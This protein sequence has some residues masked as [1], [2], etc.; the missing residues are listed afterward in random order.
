MAVRL[1][2][3]SACPSVPTPTQASLA[4]SVGIISDSANAYIS[5]SNITGSGA[6]SGRT[7][8][9]DAYQ[10]T[11][12]GIGGGTLYF[13][14]G[15]GGLGVSLTYVS[16]HDPSGRN[17]VDAHVYNTGVSAFDT[18]TV[19]AN[20][21][22]R[23]SAGA[24]AG[25][26]SANVGFAGAVVVNEISP[27]ITAYIGGPVTNNPKTI[28]LTG[29]ASVLVDSNTIAAYNDALASV[30][31]AANEGTAPTDN[32]GIDFS[33][34]ALNGGTAITG[35][36]AMFSVAGILQGGSS[37]VGLS[38][39][40]SIIATTHS[41]F[42][43]NVILNV[44]NLQVTSNDSSTIFGLTIG[45]SFGTGQFSG[46]AGTTLSSIRNTVTAQIGDSTVNAITRIAA[47]GDISVLAI[48]TSKITGVASVA[49]FSLGSAAA[50]LSVVQ[51]TIANSIAATVNNAVMTAGH[52]VTV[53]AE[54]TANISTTAVG[55]AASRSVGLAGSIALN[56]VS[57][58]VVA[59][60]VAADVIAQNNVGV[61]ANNSDNIAVVAGA[62]GVT[63][64]SPSIAGGVSV[65]TNTIGG[66]TEALIN[67]NS[68][69]DALGLGTSVLTVSTGDLVTPFDPSTPNGMTTST[70][71]LAET[72]R[73]VHGLAVVATSHQA[74][75]ANA[76]T[77]GLSI[78]PLSGAFAVVSIQN[79]MGG[80]TKASID[81]SLI[82]TRLTG[83]AT[84]L[85]D[86][87]AS[88]HSYSA[89][90]IIALSL[91]GAS[92]AA[93]NASN[94]LK[95]QTIANL[96]NSTA[97]TTNPSYTGT[98]IDSVDINAKAS[99]AAADV[100]IGTAAGIGSGASSGVL[101]N[102]NADTEAYADRG[103]L[104]ARQLIVNAKSTN[105]FFAEAGTGAGGAIGLASSYVVA[106]TSNKTLAYIG[107]PDGL[108][109]LN[110]NGKLAVTA[111][112]ENEFDSL[113][114]G[115][116]LGGGAGL[117]GMANVVT[118]SNTTRAGLYNV[119]STQASGALDGTNAAGVTVTAVENITIKPTTGAGVASAGLGLGSAT[120]VAVLG[121]SLTAEIVNT[122]NTSNPN[123][124]PGINSP[125]TVSVT[126]T[127]TKTIN[128]Q[129]VTVGIG[130]S[131]GVG[132]SV[133]V[134]LLGTTASDDANSL[135]NSGGSGTLAAVDA[136]NSVG[137][138]LTL[139]SAGIAAYRTALGTSGTTM[140]DAQIQ[141]AAQAEYS[142]LLQ[143]GTGGS[144]NFALSSS[145]LTLYAP[146]AL[147]MADATKFTTLTTNG[148]IT[149]GVLTLSTAGLA[150]YRPTAVLALGGTP[151]DTQVQAYANS[152]YRSLVS[153]INGYAFTRYQTLKSDA[154]SFVLSEAG[155]TGYRS[156]AV[157][158]LALTC[159]AGTQCGTNAEVISY[160]NDQFQKLTL[161]A[162]GAV[163]G[164][165]VTLNTTGLDAFRVAAQA[166]ADAKAM[167]IATSI[168]VA[169]PNPPVTVTDAQ[170]QAYANAQYRYLIGHQDTSN[171]P[172]AFSVSAALS[173]VNDGVFASIAG[174]APVTAANVNVNATANISTTND[175]TGIGAAGTGAGV[176]A[177]VAYT[178]INDAV[179]ASVTQASVNT[180]TLTIAARVNDGSS[181]P[182]AKVEARA[183]AG[184]G[185][186]A[187]GAA[188]GEA[189]INNSVTAGLGGTVTLTG[190]ANVSADDTSN[191]RANAFGATAGGGLALGVSK[192]VA[193]RTS[194]VSASLLDTSRV[195]AT[196][197]TISASS[198]G[199]SYAAAV[200][201]AGGLFFAG[202][203]VQSIAN[204]NSIIAAHLGKGAT[205]NVGSG[206]VKL[207]AADTPD[208]KAASLGVTV[209]G[210]VAVGTSLAT[211]TASPNVL[212][213]LDGSTSATD[214]ITAGRLT[215]SA[216]SIVGGVP[217]GE[218]QDSS[219]QSTNDF[220]PGGT[221]AA[222]WA[223]AGAGSVYYSGSGTN[224]TANNNSVVAAK[225]G[226]YV[227]LP[228]A[229]VVIK[230]DNT[231]RQFASSTGITVGGVLAVGVVLTD[232]NANTTTM[233]SLG[234]HVQMLSG[235]TK[236]FSLAA[237]GNDNNKAYS[238][239][240]SGGAIAGSGAEARTSTTST[241]TA[242]TGNADNL[243]VISLLI[244]AA[245]T[246]NYSGSSDTRQGGVIGA[247]GSVAKH[248]GDSAVAVNVGNNN[249]LYVYGTNPGSCDISACDPVVQ[250]LATNIFNNTNTG[251]SANAGAG[252][253]INGV[254]AVSTTTLTGSNTINIGKG[255]QI[256]TG[257]D[258]VNNPGS[259][260]I[261]AMSLISG[262]DQ[263]TLSAGSAIAAGAGVNSSLVVTVDNTI[264]VGDAT[265]T[266]AA[267]N[268]TIDSLG[269]ISIGTY[270]ISSASTS[271]YATTFGTILA[272]VDARAT[273]SITTNQNVTIGKALLKGVGDVNV[274]AGQ[275]GS[276][277]FSTSLVDNS[278]AVSYARGLI[279]VPVADA[280]TRLT[281]NTNLNI[282]AGARLQS[283]QNI[284]IGAYKGNLVDTAT[285]SGH[286]YEIFAI[287]V[288]AG[289]THSSS[290]ATSSVAI[291]GMLTAGIYHDLEITISCANA[292]PTCQT[293]TLTQTSGLTASYLYLDSSTFGTGRSYVTDHFHP[294][295]AP[296]LIAGLPAN[297]GSA[298]QL[299][300]LYASGGSV[301][302]SGS[303]LAGS[304][305]ITA[306]GAPI[307]NVQNNTTSSLILAGGAYIPD[308][309]VGQINFIGTA[310]AAQAPSTLGLSRP[311]PA[312]A[313]STI[314]I[315]NSYD[316]GFGGAYGPAL[317]I[318]GDIVNVAGLVNINN[319]SGS[320]GLAANLAAQ[321]VN[322]TIPNGA[323][324]VSANDPSG[325]YLAGGSPF[326]EWANYILYPGG[327][328]RDGVPNGDVAAAYLA[329]TVAG[330]A[331][332]GDSLNR[333]LYGV[334]YAPGN[335]RNSSTIFFGGCIP[336][337][338]GGNGAGCQQY[339]TGYGGFAPGSVDNS[340]T[341]GFAG[342][343]SNT[344]NASFPYIT[345]YSLTKSATSYT[346]AY[347]VGSQ[348]SNQIY[349][350]QVAI[351]ANIIDIN[352]LIT[353]GRNT[354]WSVNLPSSLTDPAIVSRTPVTQ[355]VCTGIFGSSCG[356]QIVDYNTTYSG[357]AISIFKAQYDLAILTNPAANALLTVNVG[358]NG[359][360]AAT[361]NAATNTISLANVNASSGGSN[362]LLDGRIISTNA[363]GHIHV[364]GG[365]GNVQ[366]ANNTG[367]DLIVNGINTGNSAAA[368]ALTS[369]VKIVDRLQATAT[370]TTTYIYSPASNSI[371]KYIT[372]NGANADS[373][374]CMAGN[375][376]TI[377]ASTIDY[378]TKE[379]LRFQWQ[380]YATI[381]RSAGT[382]DAASRTN[383]AL[384]SAHWLFTSGTP[385]NP[386]V[387]LTPGLTVST[388]PQGTLL[389]GQSTTLPIFQERITGS[390]LPSYFG[391]SA[392]QSQPIVYSGCDPG[393]TCNYGFPQNY[394]YN[395]SNN[396]TIYQS[397][398]N[399]DYPIS[400]SLT[401]TQ[402]IK[403]DNQFKVDFGGNP[404]AT[405]NIASNSNVMFANSIINPSGNLTATASGSVEKPGN[406]TQTSA[407]PIL[408][409]SFN[410]TAAGS[411]GTVTKPLNVT[412]TTNGATPGRLAANAGNAGV[413]L[414]L[415]SGATLGRVSSGNTSTGFGD[416]GI[417]A[418]GS[419]L[420]GTDTLVTGRNLTLISTSGSVGTLLAPLNISA[421][422]T[423]LTS[424]GYQ[425]GVVNV[426]AHGDV[427]LIQTA[428][429][430]AYPG[431]LRIGLIASAGGD[432]QINV[433]RGEILDASGQTS[434]QA[435]SP[436]QV[437]AISQA[438][439]LTPLDGSTAASLAV[440]AGFE[441]TVNRDL[442]DYTR[443][444][445]NGAL[446]NGS[447]VLVPAALATYRDLATAAIGHAASDTE[448]QTY[449]NSLYQLY[450]SDFTR[451]FGTTWQT[452]PAII[453]YG[454]YVAL[455][456]AGT[457]IN[458][459]FRLTA[460]DIA[461][462]RA[463]AT[464][465]LGIAGRNATDAETQT[466][467]AGL[468]AT[469][470]GQVTFSA[471]PAVAFSLL[472]ASGSLQNGTFVLTN[473]GILS[474]ASQALTA[475]NY[476]TF[477][478]LLTNGTL[479]SGTFALTSAGIAA[480]A[481]ALL[482]QD[483]QNFQNLN[484]YGSV[485]NGTFTLTAAGV[486]FFRQA[487][488]TAQ[489][490]IPTDAQV[491]AYANTLYQGY[492]QTINTAE[493]SQ[494]QTLVQT[495]KTSAASNYQYYANLVANAYCETSGCSASER[496]TFLTTVPVQSYAYL[497]HPVDRTALTSLLGLGTVTNGVFTLIAGNVG[498]YAQTGLSPSNFA[499]YTGLL[500]AGTVSNNV[501]ALTTAG[502]VQFAQSALTT[503]YQT[504]QSL[505]AS[506]ATQL[507][508][509][510]FSNAGVQQFAQSGI[511][512]AYQ[513]YQALVTN[514][515]ADSNGVFVLSASGLTAYRPLAA[516]ALGIANPTD[517]QVQAYAGQQYQNSIFTGGN[518]TYQQYSQT[519][520]TGAQTQLQTLLQI[521]RV[522][523][524][525]TESNPYCQYNCSAI[526]YSDRT[527]VA[528]Y[529]QD[530]LS[531][532][533]YTA[534]QTLVSNGSFNPTTGAFTLN[535]T[536]AA[537]AALSSVALIGSD[538]LAFQTLLGRGTVTN[539]QFV[540]SSAGAV[541]A[542][543]QL[544]GTGTF[545]TGTFQLTSSGVAA[546]ASSA[547]GYAA[548]QKLL[549][550]G[551][552]NGTTLVLNDPGV[553]YYAPSALSAANYATFSGFIASGNGEVVGGVLTLTANGISAFR[554]AATTSL[555]HAASDAEVQ[556]YARAQYQ[557]FAITVQSYANGQYQSYISTFQNAA[558]SQ[559]QTYA[560]QIRTY[561]NN[562]QNNNGCYFNCTPPTPLA[563]SA[564]AS[565]MQNH[566][567]DLGYTQTDLTA[568]QALVAK[569]A[570]QNGVYSLTSA[571]I[572]LSFADP[573]L[574][575]LK[576]QTFQTVLAGGSVQNGTFVL[577]NNGIIAASRSLA[578][579]ADP[580]T[581][582][583][584]ILNT[585]QRIRI[586]YNSGLIQLDNGLLVSGEQATAY[587]DW[588]QTAAT[589]VYAAG[590][591]Q[592]QGIAVAQYQNYVAPI[593]VYGNGQYQSLL[594]TIQAGAA[595]QY[596]SSTRTIQ[597]YGNSQYQTLTSNG[598]TQ[599]A[600]TTQGVLDLIANN[601]YSDGQIVAA[602]NRSALAPSPT[603]VGNNGNV[604]IVGRNV[605]LTTGAS[606]GSLAPNVVVNL[607]DLR[608]GTVTADQQA[609]I[610]A[611][612]APGSV[613]FDVLV[614]GVLRTGQVLN[615][616][617]TS[618]D[619]NNIVAAQ[620]AQISPVFVNA[621]G[622][623][624]ATASTTVYVQAASALS[625]A[626][627]QL[628]TSANVSTTLPVA[629]LALGQ[630]NAGGD[631]TVQ[632][633]QNITAALNGSGI[634]FYSRQI[635]T[636]GN[637]TIAAGG[638]VGTAANAVTFEIG[639]N[640]VSGSAGADAYLKGLGGDIRVGR[641]SAG[642]TLIGGGTGGTLSLTAQNGN[643]L[644]YLPGVA[645][646]AT[647]IV[648]NASGNVGSSTTP[649]QVQDASGGTLSGAVTGGAWIYGS[650]LSNQ[651]TPVTLYIG[652]FSAAAGVSLLADADIDINGAVVSGN[653]AIIIRTLRP[654]S[655]IVMGSMSSVT[656]GTTI[657]LESADNIVL[658]KLQ[659]TGAGSAG[660]VIALS[661]GGSI[662]GNGDG[663][664]NLLTGAPS[665]SVSLTASSIGT[666]VQRVVISAPS[667]SAT[668]GT[669]DLYLKTLGNTGFASLTTAY[670]SVDVLGTG[671]LVF[672]SVQAGTANGATGN[673][674]A[675][676]SAAAGATIAVGTATT[677]GTQT[678]H[679][680]DDL[681]FTTLTTTGAT[682][683]V[684][685]TSDQGKIAG[686]SVSANRSATLVAATTNQGNSLIATNGS[687]VLRAG[688]LIDWTTLNAGTTLAATST[689]AGITFGTATSG[690]MQTLQADNDITFTTLT[691]T[692]A[693]GDVNA[694]SD[695]GK[696]AGGSVSANRSATLTAAT[697]NKGNSLTAT[698]GSIVLR[699]G[700]LIDWTMLNAGT[701]LAATSIGAGIT[702]GTATS[703]GTQALQADNDITFTT[704]T[705]TGA[706]GDVNAT[707]DQGK[708]A[709][710]SVS[711]NRSATLVAATTNKGNSL[712]ATN[713]SIVLRAGGLIDWTTL[714]AG[715]TL[716]ATS[717]G[718]GITFGTATSGGTQALQADNDITFTT[719]TTTGATGDVNATSDQGK[720]AG[721]SV[722]ANR[723]ATLVAATTNKGNSLTATNGSIVLRAGGLIDW[724]TLN[725]GTTLAATST[726]AGITFGTATSG[727]TQTLQADND[728]AFSRL[729]S[730][731]ITGDR[732]DISATSTLGRIV[733]GS[734]NASGNIN[735]VGNGI[736][737]DTV[738][739]AANVSLVSTGDVTGHSASA[740]GDLSISAGALPGTTG[741]IAVDMLRG[742]TMTL[743]A[744][745]AI[746]IA[747][748]VVSTGLTLH[749][750]DI[751][752]NITQNAGP[753]APPLMLD[754]TGPNGAVA[755]SIA[756]NL[757]A[758]SVE[759]THL[760]G[761]DIS[762]ATNGLGVK[763]DNGYVPGRLA[764]AT[765]HQLVLLN[766]RSPT[767][768][769]NSNVQLF[770]PGFGFNLNLQ[771]NSLS[772]NSFVVDYT[773]G[774]N[775]TDYLGGVAYDGASLVRDFVRTNRL[776]EG[777]P[778]QLFG[779]TARSTLFVTGTSP[780]TYIDVH[781]PKKSVQTT[782]SGPAVNVGQ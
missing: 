355:Y 354:N 57:T 213:Q 48:D 573:A 47:A 8:D 25:G 173:N 73:T 301:N 264:N 614:N 541:A 307:I 257:T 376:T 610:A 577:N 108:T 758:P 364:N 152:Q 33:G 484:Q 72:T 738:S 352:G 186:A 630:I 39:I 710:G 217:D 262:A 745:G 464:A 216:S 180:G 365:Y 519:I 30:A 669:G 481:S 226:D 553:I 451:A 679:A 616:L 103:S 395:N 500:A 725:A 99:Q 624:N 139:S 742:T 508:T 427:A 557:S 345:Y 59:S 258:P 182:A 603:T 715:T 159:T 665:S 14:G 403:A 287:P 425:G 438:L 278:S 429:S 628:L 487:A 670:G 77:A 82:D 430:A 722:S 608:N 247:A 597:A 746:H 12:I 756:A 447:F 389:T 731:G 202:T 350:G 637:L 440:I 263:V 13:A 332:D 296:T 767:P 735:F 612:S 688:G 232:A 204:D 678:L 559:Y 635:V 317:L 1:R 90:Y 131:A 596:Q 166:D 588:V 274:A 95:R 223:T 545:A 681:S 676:N 450:V 220:T 328:P 120:N 534:L 723:S 560:T 442:A 433:P 664:T 615:Q 761:I 208:V 113:A 26:I 92:G 93:A 401:L 629:S 375:C 219:P 672:G 195:T 253:G 303:S 60:V 528:S 291:N 765:P 231:T 520:Q 203:G 421:N 766:N 460:A 114:A 435:L 666:S 149:N 16:I 578:D 372:S 107:D 542:F 494:Y 252:G 754:F 344:N 143:N 321:Q 138:T 711:A 310:G 446:Q 187:V 736:V 682:G 312:G 377:N 196:G 503:T 455:T 607:G 439:R 764:I 212:A 70:P 524:N 620:L 81:N 288:T 109:T 78:F 580:A 724:T 536:P 778:V 51:S 751:G 351:K 46:L 638:S 419:L 658:G 235:G 646:S 667:I 623:F 643:I 720:I 190:A 504:Y 5:N 526:D 154:V 391:G 18:L 406:I 184:A 685:A 227:N 88:S 714:N 91:G 118:V 183:G 568:F 649:F 641:L 327:N 22:S 145:G 250:L 671:S 229:D 148:T 510:V 708:I 56:S 260:Q 27:T 592:I 122:T 571:G 507:G 431:D 58:D 509:Y 397:L 567:A 127:G 21:A 717:I 558:S 325:L 489:N 525:S 556:T 546:S 506:G 157:S 297:A 368:T 692:G 158:G 34:S 176:G 29:T 17:A 115:G 197:L 43:A 341:W 579:T 574:V 426:A 28:S 544:A 483:Y 437:D 538:N 777:L 209:S 147:N 600:Q 373:S 164:G 696:I 456:G 119:L 289:N 734:V 133:G 361:Y 757:N 313:L 523:A 100:V 699:A 548:T 539:N 137:N 74:V 627:S 595:S 185:A 763:I 358:T 386:W 581:T 168:G 604:N 741:S 393:G 343:T 661:A 740:A 286:G 194:S 721:G 224:A 707:S 697:T 304:G 416:V 54:S 602:L 146:R 36:A 737:F 770:Q 174:N 110:L 169:A 569:G 337:Y 517:A 772:T 485:Q 598:T 712:T 404:T 156:Q 106:N 691:T 564:L 129:T 50:G 414:S 653:G 69:V 7:I 605:A 144:T 300:Q 94:V 749:A 527:L 498:T 511:S 334:S 480:E 172:D 654:I 475:A 543:Q 329:N 774:S 663:Q 305:T 726:G 561:Y 175:A 702:F 448:T 495:I 222:A 462:Y 611:A 178:R 698:N 729:V 165:V 651:T 706:T 587:F 713:G 67:S 206:E 550:S 645:V 449:A 492:V 532:S 716:A 491:R 684:N 233:A 423:P 271:S 366:I 585:A 516:S 236:A 244:S 739:S 86:I 23:I 41:A 593:T 112:N 457:V 243:N 261:S 499:T 733:G 199:S 753:G 322:I 652:N 422:A 83:I 407:N 771:S 134:I 225:V 335:P 162:N 363:L 75:V 76:V 357:G 80:L 473:T 97:G 575:S 565:Y 234:D 240:G 686:G 659:T 773:A 84:P 521:V 201:G 555:G 309:A 19:I 255:T 513:N 381:Q 314:A 694:T 248:T 655:D 570:V 214:S 294:D 621:S 750:S 748:L 270:T 380:L 566:L 747:D 293:P 136:T 85:I 640:L 132:A 362:V 572:A 618:L 331:T 2:S 191:I 284:N 583:A 64:L 102:F 617:G 306:Y 61:L 762:I 432:V 417:T 62:L 346:S 626:A 606:V 673:F 101:N 31:L 642:T 705:T 295:V 340:K 259:V 776:G 45:A 207:T 680:N 636:P 590:V 205:I 116:V 674:S 98:G 478:N 347:L 514:G 413:Y 752:V 382:Y 744:T 454:A 482:T 140:S 55:I 657:S 402:S 420:A 79:S 280:T 68:K 6:A 634:P 378:L 311:S 150:A 37:N 35:G 384:V 379:G 428:A 273:T 266:A 466:Y 768:A 369:T 117:A 619:P 42:I 474:Y 547:L 647:N 66:N 412:L 424:G 298:F 96:T 662:T 230:A 591:Q 540:Y 359:S 718:A 622:V 330:N 254:G 390:V 241:V 444:L 399:Y 171:A 353:A 695:Q 410:A 71:S 530:A 38:L 394:T 469:M 582:S 518:T 385:R 292:I 453:N 443:L 586:I 589:Q 703:G 392:G 374:S 285:A 360:I 89:N 128:A 130:N 732:G 759:F 251:S 609:A 488:S 342:S 370:N 639:G 3:E 728:I 467:A 512:A 675:D 418:T 151:T 632:A 189:L 650:T 459:V 463:A 701:T 434:A 501:L 709:G 690:G 282:A 633:P 65:V 111:D 302:I 63:V 719:L 631:V 4:G 472:N 249:I 371:R 445:A 349:G 465:A 238:L 398:W 126:A 522:Y 211:A 24:A 167:A 660:T 468:Y 40:D 299:G 20:D 179:V 452:N 479:S 181:S 320:Y 142:A 537:V 237:A 781:A 493:N 44:R 601:T 584:D 656:A 769:G 218:S 155:I 228:V 387:Y 400:G 193:N 105:A 755:N 594:Q 221:S 554:A 576:A 775:I 316:T 283:G 49:A 411:I 319:T 405:L 388:T 11:N 348:S 415:N 779:D 687:I 188:V 338:G 200:A 458:G 153:G 648:L 683:D 265:A 486:A 242:N 15:K 497:L 246:D 124:S 315:N 125:G 704:L 367:I 743:N 531:A 356:Q 625:A 123:S 730:Y 141:S 210:Y 461:S 326:S 192:A 693:T 490:P 215:V 780:D 689:G 198:E 700:G 160:A 269:N 275:E 599:P 277:A 668:L 470:K 53:D 279:G 436:A 121:S 477:R 52:Y 533:N 268:V 161:S 562:N 441:T 290:V 644:S 551:A 336:G 245:H 272:A 727:G 170:V 613:T 549:S 502:L 396:D 535:S 471:T 135:I 239:A 256:V 87:S 529:A 10:T 505:T 760:A 324:A 782:G 32:S 267:D 177:A 104:K 409:G 677:S 496:N 339:D 318:T 476:G 163:S 515:A 333:S 383:P 408:T 9:V 563:D 552:A 281:N 276:G 323:V 308:T